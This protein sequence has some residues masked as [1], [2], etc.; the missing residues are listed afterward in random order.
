MAPDLSGPAGSA[1]PNTIRLGAS[2][3]AG[4]VHSA[5]PLPC[6]GLESLTRGLDHLEH[7]PV[8]ALPRST[9]DTGAAGPCADATMKIERLA[10]DFYGC[11][12]SPRSGHGSR[13]QA[14]RQSPR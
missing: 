13:A 12:R 14:V 1:P 4:A 9:E 10:S 7:W 8:V 2:F 11:Q 3:K 6:P 5:I